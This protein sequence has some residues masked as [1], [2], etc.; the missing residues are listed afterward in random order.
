MLLGIMTRHRSC[1]QQVVQEWPLPGQQGCINAKDYDVKEWTAQVPLQG[2]G[3]PHSWSFAHKARVP[4]KLHIAGTA[5][6]MQRSMH[7]VCGQ[8]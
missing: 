2:A 7:T 8:H 4:I 1:L 3:L 5:A 6:R